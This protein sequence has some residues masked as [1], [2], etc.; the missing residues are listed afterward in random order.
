MNILQSQELKEKIIT[1][2]NFLIIS[3]RE[4]RIIQ[5][6]TSLLHKYY[7]INQKYDLLAGKYA[8]KWNGTGQYTYTLEKTVVGLNTFYNSFRLFF[9]LNKDTN[10]LTPAIDVVKDGAYLDSSDF[11]N[12][13]YNTIYD[14][15][16]SEHYVETTGYDVFATPR[17]ELYYIFNDLLGFD[18]SSL[19][20]DIINVIL[21]QNSFDEREILSSDTYVISNK[22]SLLEF[23]SLFVN[24]MISKN[25]F[26]SLTTNS[27]EINKSLTQS[28]VNMFSI[29]TEPYSSLEV[30]DDTITILDDSA[31]P[32]L[33]NNDMVRLSYLNNKILHRNSS[34]AFSAKNN[35]QEMINY[36]LFDLLSLNTD[37]FTQ[38][39]IAEKI[40]TNLLARDFQSSKAEL[41][42]LI[43]TYYPEVSNDFYNSS[44]GVVF[45][46]LLAYLHDIQSNYIDR[47]Q[48]ES[49]F[50]TMLE[51]NRIHD[52]VNQFGY[53]INYGNPAFLKA[54]LITDKKSINNIVLQKGDI[55]QF[56]TVSLPQ[57]IENGIVCLSL[58]HI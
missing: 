53:P 58:I 56:G 9:I 21:P 6:D 26:F 17:E 48:R 25:Y 43:A 19:Y 33:V 28:I 11:I 36:D 24:Y 40:N 45:L 42:N 16:S 14:Y 12:Y 55:L 44:V 10:E 41:I 23:F 52:Y 5:N 27:S 57:D 30:A 34:I 20:R 54:D 4:K 7:G 49:I 37:T 51:S 22:I 31:S 50:H 39:G 46:D 32:E 38:M 15:F 3:S 29:Y 2:F 8:Y 18:F 35:Y 13:G 1:F 47:A